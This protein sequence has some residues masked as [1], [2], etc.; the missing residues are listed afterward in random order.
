MIS[1]SEIEE[2]DIAGWDLFLET[3]V[4]PSEFRAAFG[5]DPE[6]MERIGAL[7]TFRDVHLG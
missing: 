5:F 3:G 1:G 4:K 2:G 7:L 6:S